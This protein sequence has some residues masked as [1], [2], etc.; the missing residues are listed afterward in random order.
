LGANVGSVL[1]PEIAADLHRLATLAL[2]GEAFTG[3]PI[4]L[5]TSGEPRW[6][7]LSVAPVHDD[8]RNVHRLSA[9][10]RNVSQHFRTAAR[11]EALSRLTDS[12]RDA[13]NA[14]AIE[15]TAARILG[16]ALH[17]HRVCYG[18]IDPDADTL[19]VDHDWNAPGLPSLQAT[20]HL[21]NYG[22][23]V[24]TLKRRDVVNIADVRED[25]T[26]ASAAEALEKT[27][28]ARALLAVPVIEYGRLVA[29]LYIKHETVREWAPED[30]ALIREVA[31]RTRIA[32]ERIRG[33]AALRDNEARLRFLDTLGKEA[34]KST[35]A[36]AILATTT[37]MLGQHL[38]V[39]ICALCG[40]GC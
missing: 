39:A 33:V 15:C 26:T 27:R 1:P 32:A 6:L 31:E 28:G 17:V 2:S 23:F 9:I 18:T 7:Q 12:F 14:A 3:E 29:I 4:C 19:H 37:R 21:R 22:S 11:R 5:P 40:Y 13:D 8:A 35:D 16:E 20:L 34:A 30:V 25:P 38:N 24:D 36:D 10:I